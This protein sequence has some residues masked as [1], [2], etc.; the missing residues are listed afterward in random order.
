MKN[1]QNTFEAFVRRELADFHPEPSDQ[2]WQF[3]SERI[4]A[5]KLLL[6]NGGQAPKIIN[7]PPKSSGF[8]SALLGL[9]ILVS[10][11]VL[12][13]LLFPFTKE[14]IIIEEPR[15]ATNQQIA[16]KE[17]VDK[18]T[19]QK[20]ERSAPVEMEKEP[21]QVKKSQL[22]HPISDTTSSIDSNLSKEEQNNLASPKELDGQVIR[23]N[24][25][26]P[27]LSN[28]K[29]K[30]IIRNLSLKS[31]QLIRFDQNTEREKQPLLTTEIILVLD[32]RD[33]RKKREQ[34][35]VALQAYGFEIQNVNFK[36]NLTT[37][38]K[39][40]LHLRH[41]KGL[42]W[43][44]YV[45]GFRQLEIKVILNENGA[46]KGFYYRFNNRGKYS[47]FVT[48]TDKGKTKYRFSK[49]GWEGDQNFEN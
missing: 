33:G 22:Y 27:K 18:I 3:L 15:V 44:V 45:K 13:L 46:T 7:T 19:L 41:N 2:V 17:L 5:D 8:S 4:N 16:S 20:K 25:Q 32:R 11:S 36:R 14:Q 34:F 31:R 12:A 6:Q 38:R 49:W 26:L 37:I 28:K 40:K 47:R 43:K 39:L 10:V 1:K 48:I 23:K 35:L 9:F 42:D 21:V 24:F 29:N 30:P